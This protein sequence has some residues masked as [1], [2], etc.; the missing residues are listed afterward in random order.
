MVLV[1]VSLLT[2][3]VLYLVGVPLI[4][5]ESHSYSIGAKDGVSTIFLSARWPLVILL[6]TTLVGV[7]LSVLRK[8]EKK[9]A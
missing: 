7:L 1:G 8:H 5:Y 6:V 4:S 3:F 2:G 9:D